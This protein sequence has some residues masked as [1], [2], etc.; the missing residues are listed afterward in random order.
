MLLRQKGRRLGEEPEEALL[1][2]TIV[3]SSA[4]MS[5]VCACLWRGRSG[6]VKGDR[7]AK[8]FCTVATTQQSQ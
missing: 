2:L 1:K 6:F 7:T 8:G 3:S 5:R 4:G